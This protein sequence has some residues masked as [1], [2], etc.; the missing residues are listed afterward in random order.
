MM[1]PADTEVVM[2][3]KTSLRLL[4]AACLLLLSLIPALAQTATSG[5][6][7]GVVTD[8]SGALIPGVSV[9]LQQHTTNAKMQVTT[10]S[11]GHYV[12]PVVDPS[13]YT[14]TFA[15]NEFQNAVVSQLKVHEQYDYYYKLWLNV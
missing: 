14:L 6:L 15:S 9:I 7:S 8:L 10:D 13:D 4:G 2:S 5:L 1:G 11:L 3:G 12:F